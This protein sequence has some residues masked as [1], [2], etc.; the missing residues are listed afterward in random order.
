MYHEVSLIDVVKYRP[1]FIQV[2]EKVTKITT[3][4]QIELNPGDELEVLGTRM[5]ATKTGVQHYLK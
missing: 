5:R 3:G 2:V 4:V 1:R